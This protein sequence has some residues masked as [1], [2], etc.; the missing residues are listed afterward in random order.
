MPDALRLGTEPRPAR[1]LAAGPAGP[2]ASADERAACAR[3]AGGLPAPLLKVDTL[4]TELAVG[5][6]RFDVL[7]GVSFDVGVGERLGMVGE[8]G[9]GKSMTALS[10]LRLLPKAARIRAGAIEFDSQDIRT[11]PERAMIAL[12]GAGIGMVFQDPMTSLNPVLRIE[13]QLTEGM[14]LHLGLSPARCRER[15][16]EMLERVRI[17][18]PEQVLRSYPHQLSG[19]MRQRIAIAMA[20]SCR[21]KLVIADEPTT[22]LD[23]TIQAEVIALLQELTANDGTSVILISHSLDLVAQYCDRVAVMYAGRVVEDRPTRD[24]VGDSRHPYTA[25]LIAS[26]PNVDAPRVERFKAIPGQPPLPSALPPGCPYHPRC[27]RAL[28]HCTETEPTLSDGNGLAACWRV[29]AST[30]GAA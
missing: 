3:R 2:P 7:R 29:G 18:R 26:A 16:L 17:A 15:A 21:P 27:L 12:R 10:I 22:A 19:G 11:L 4:H 9:S 1:R 25:D 28:E 23:V 6:V 8:S 30:S 14:E 24:L 20:L 13:R 5:G